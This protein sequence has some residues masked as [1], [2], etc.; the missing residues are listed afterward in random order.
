VRA[1][2]V[3]VGLSAG[4][5]FFATRVPDRP[6]A[7]ARCPGVVVGL[8]VVGS[9]LLLAP[10]IAVVAD[11]QSSGEDMGPLAIAVTGLTV[12][13]IY[14]GSAIYGARARSRC[15]EL[16]VHELEYQV[17]P[18]QPVQ[19]EIRVRKPMIG[20]A[21]LHCAITAP[22]VGVCFFDGDQCAKEANQAGGTCEV[23]T[24]GW[25]F[26]AKN[27]ATARSETTCAA[28]RV[29]CD[30]RRTL[31]FSDRTF[32]VTTC[33]TYSVASNPAP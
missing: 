27:L 30:A 21:P 32:A 20:E 25:C 10:V 13:G 18:A 11:R 24:S 28:S 2:T 14:L 26:D 22:D 17:D 23:R 3:V 6:P 15:H 19:R 1:L 31:L 5:S 8:D 9:L 16:K 29:H 12:G 4:C 33:G 7:P